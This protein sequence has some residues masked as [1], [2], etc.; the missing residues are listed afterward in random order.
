M[1]IPLL[2]FSIE[3]CSIKLTVFFTV[4]WS[5]LIEPDNASQYWIKGMSKKEGYYN[6]TKKNIDYICFIF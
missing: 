6:R 4:R 1:C 2:D 5:E 3:N